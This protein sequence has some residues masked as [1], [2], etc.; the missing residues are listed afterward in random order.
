VQGQLGRDENFV[1][2][3]LAEIPA[4]LSAS[5]RKRLPL[6]LVVREFVLGRDELLKRKHERGAERE[7]NKGEKGGKSAKGD[8]QGNDNAAEMLTT[9][10]LRGEVRSR[11][12]RRAAGNL[13]HG[14]QAGQRLGL[15]PLGPEAQ[16]ATPRTRPEG[17]AVAGV[18]FRTIISIAF[19]FTAI[20]AAVYI[21]LRKRRRVHR[22][23]TIPDICAGAVP[24]SPTANAQGQI[25]ARCEG[26]YSWHCIIM[27]ADAG[28]F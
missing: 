7:Q 21:R 18:D 6:S 14:E 11:L 9:S 3:A 20:A 22:V 28:A 26:R 4:G 17:T 10:N 8:A 13:H 2:L 23:V 15:G 25:K 16:M 24:C 27:N 5:E 12:P 19:M 1:D